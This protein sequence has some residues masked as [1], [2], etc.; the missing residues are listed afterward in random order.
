VQVLPAPVRAACLASNGQC[1]E[2]NHGG[3]VASTESE[4]LEMDPAA[5]RHRQLGSR[6]PS[7]FGTCDPS[8]GLRSCKTAATIEDH[9]NGHRFD[10]ERERQLEQMVPDRL[11]GDIRVMLRVT[12]KTPAPASCSPRC[13]RPWLRGSNSLNL[14][15]AIVRSPFVDVPTAANA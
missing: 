9:S 2:S 8:C 3:S 7:I 1:R 11:H 4:T 5:V 14:G 15:I 6:S 10:D 13:R 12:L